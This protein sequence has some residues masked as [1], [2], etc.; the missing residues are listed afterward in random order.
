M[1][2][3]TVNIYI[4]KWDMR[5]TLAL[6]IIAAALTTGCGKNTD[7]TTDTSDIS[8]GMTEPVPSGLTNTNEKPQFE[9]DWQRLYYVELWKF[10]DN[11][12]VMF[13]IYDLDGDGT[14]ELLV[15]EGD[16]HAAVCV[17]YTVSNGEL[18]SLGTYGRWGDFIYDFELNYIL[19]NYSQ[20]GETFTR[21]YSYENGKVAEVMSLY[22]YSGVMP[23]Q[24]EEKYHINGIDVSYDV[25]S[26]EYDKY[27]FDVREDFCVRKYN[28]SL[29]EIER[30]LGQYK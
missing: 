16:Y 18:I 29:S 24:P 3:L 22:G 13:N 26:A 2:V 17:L 30:V 12:W 4:V 8:A 27:S 15:S 25:Y 23:T 14:P 10:V 19:C 7:N 1:R 28:A 5:K 20:S 21:I 11:P 9:H 6:I